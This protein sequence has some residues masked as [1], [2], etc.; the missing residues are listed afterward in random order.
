MCLGR[1][2]QKLMCVILEGPNASL[3]KH[4]GPLGDYSGPILNNKLPMGW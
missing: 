2:L 4:K 3:R 1:K